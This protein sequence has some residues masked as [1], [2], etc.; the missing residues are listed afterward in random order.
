[1]A[2]PTPK[3]VVYGERTAA[4]QVLWW[5]KSLGLTQGE[6]ERRAG[7]GHNTIS[8]IEQSEVSPRIETIEKI[9]EALSITVEALQFSNPTPRIQEDAA[10]EESIDGRIAKLPEA[11]RAKAKR[12]VN[13]VLDLL[14]GV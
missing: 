10:A 6:L 3:K 9:A 11:V 2:S 8:R 7:L 14:E 1:M 4:S 13:D 12:M 5:R